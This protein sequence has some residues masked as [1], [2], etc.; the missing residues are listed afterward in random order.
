VKRLA[1]SMAI[2]LVACSWLTA[3]AARVG[4]GAEVPNPRVDYVGKINELASRGRAENLNAGPYYQ[5][6]IELWVEGTKEQTKLAKEGWPADLSVRE[7]AVLRQWL[8]SNSQA[9]AQLE[10]GA[11]RPYYWVRHSSKDGT[12]MGI[13]MPRLAESRQL[14]FAIA[15]RAKLAAAEGDFDRAVT[16]VATCYGFGAHL[17]DSPFLVAQLVGIAVR[18]V[19]L[20]T[21]FDILDRTRPDRVVLEGL[22]RQ[23]EQLSR[24]ESF[25]PNLQAEKFMMLDIIQRVFTDDGR[26]DGRIHRPSVERLFQNAGLGTGSGAGAILQANLSRRQTTETVEKV[27]GYFDS[28]AQKTPWQWKAERIDP[29]KEIE[30]MA[31]ENALVGLLC[32]A[33]GRVTEIYSRSRA[34]T[35]ALITTLAVLRYKA[36]RGRA[37]GRL[38]ELVLGGYLKAVPNDPFSGSGFVYRQL[39]GDFTLYSFAEDCDDDGGARSRWGTGGK[40]GDQ[41]F[42]PV[43]GAQVAAG[44]TGSGRPVAG[45]GLERP[46]KSLHEV[47]TA[48]DVGQVKLHISSGTDVNA[49]DMAGYAALF[50]AARKGHKEVAELLVRAGADVNAQ[51]HNGNRPL[52]Y[53]AWFGHYDVCEVLV[54]GGADVGARNLTGGTASVMA[55]AKGHNQIVEL[56][57]RRPVGGGRSG[58]GQSL[59]RNLLGGKGGDVRSPAEPNMVVDANA[60]KAKIKEFAGLE[61]ELGRVDRRSRYEV[62][63]WL[64]KGVD[65]KAKL[66][67]EVHAQ[68]RAEMNLIRKV[69]AA[70]K[71]VKTTAAIEKLLLERAKRYAGLAKRMAEDARATSQQVAQPGGRRS[72][73]YGGDRQS[74]GRQRYST[75]GRT[76]S[77][78]AREEEETVEDTRGQDLYSGGQELYDGY[79]DYGRGAGPY[80]GGGMVSMGVVDQNE[81]EMREW[82]QVTAENKLGLVKSVHKRIA[83][84]LYSIRK[85][86]VAEDAKKTT[87]TIDGVLLDRQV[88]LGRLLERIQSQS[89][90]SQETESL[91]SGGRTG[92]YD[93]RRGYQQGGYRGRTPRGGAA[94]QGEAVQEETGSD[95][96]RRRR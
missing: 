37:P 66:A 93:S 85:P 61:A 21:A 52:H 38:D 88:R 81:M 41:V 71:A 15:G 78:P 43:E 3:G 1:I 77:R 40:G 34:Q 87:A 82:L 65:N 5:K 19:A 90:D 84:R 56:L 17:S 62:G 46:S 26:G 33:V 51:D 28:L 72:S 9:M 92:P 89:R 96:P 45:T 59:W 57:S 22:Q 27:F 32:P 94:E 6:A 39:G 47:A 25:K 76:R 7:Q 83:V 23:I 91:P 18:A 13:V 64:K 95:A 73:R 63:E 48:G 42:W 60:V 2:F 68:E 75:G 4:Q 14:T 54:S 55:K 36:D 80:G 20:G 24:D 69:A 30:R 16:D 8:R 86:A 31:K 53:A 12:A 74:E 11:K 10:I 50:Y 70:E 58:I 67:K 79:E 49:K 29:D 35:D 44:Q